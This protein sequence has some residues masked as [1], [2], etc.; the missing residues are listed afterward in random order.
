MIVGIAWFRGQ[1]DFDAY[2]TEVVIDELCLVVS[3]GNDRSM[4]RV[5]TMGVR[6]VTELPNV[7]RDVYSAPVV[8]RRRWESEHGRSRERCSGQG[9]I[10]LLTIFGVRLEQAAFGCF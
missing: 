2:G 1:G 9:Q 7:G 6:E 8:N 4:Q 3:S 10:M 5:E